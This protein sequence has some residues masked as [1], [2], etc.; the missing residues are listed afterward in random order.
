[1]GCTELKHLLIT[2][3]PCF[4]AHSEPLACEINGHRNTLEDSNRRF[5]KQQVRDTVLTTGPNGRPDLPEI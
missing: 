1:M 4:L 2:Q 5:C 3:L